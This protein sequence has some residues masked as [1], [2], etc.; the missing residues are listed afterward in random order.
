[1]AL[2]IGDN[3]AKTMVAATTAKDFVQAIRCFKDLC[4]SQIVYGSQP[5]PGGRKTTMVSVAV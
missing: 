3:R 4:I 1:M 5:T 2:A